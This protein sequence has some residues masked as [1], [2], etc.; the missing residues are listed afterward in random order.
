MVGKRS[1]TGVTVRRETHALLTRG[2]VEAGPLIGRR[3]SL[4]AFVSAAAR[5]AL[6]HPDELAAELR[7]GE[8][9]S[10]QVEGGAA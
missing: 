3:V 5:I 2:A 7:G 8:G 4:D 10:A 9:A 6:R 1:G